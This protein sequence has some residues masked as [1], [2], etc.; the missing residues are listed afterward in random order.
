M[1]DNDKK[2]DNTAKKISLLIKDK[3]VKVND[4]KL[5]KKKNIF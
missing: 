4:K 5:L 1:K 3:Q 2:L